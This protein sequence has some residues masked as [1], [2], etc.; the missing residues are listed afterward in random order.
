MG[1]LQ[2]NLDSDLPGVAAVIDPHLVN[3]WGIAFAPTSPFWL[4]DEGADVATLYQGNGSVLSLVVSMPSPPTGSVFNPSGTSFR[5]TNGNAA[6]FLFAT[7][8]GQIV[9]WNGGLGS[10]AVVEFNATD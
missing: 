4:S 3:P 9:G 5:L 2:T 6:N 1:Y 7:L 8:T 10:T